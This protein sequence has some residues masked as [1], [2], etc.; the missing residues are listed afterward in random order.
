MRVL[1]EYKGKRVDI[2][3]PI[4][5]RQSKEETEVALSGLIDDALRVLSTDYVRVEK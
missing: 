5:L 2:K 3:D 4:T 1:I